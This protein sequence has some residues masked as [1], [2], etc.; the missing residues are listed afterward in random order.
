[1]IQP[2]TLSVANDDLEALRSRLSQVRWPEKETVEDWSQGVPS[3]AGQSIVFLLA[4][5]I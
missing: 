4:R 2:F 5:P 3:G 1:M